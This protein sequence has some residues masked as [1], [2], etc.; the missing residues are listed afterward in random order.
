VIIGVAAV[1]L[2]YATALKA[3]QDLLN[4][5]GDDYKRSMQKVPIP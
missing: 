4:K 1:V 3:D 5:F 2:N